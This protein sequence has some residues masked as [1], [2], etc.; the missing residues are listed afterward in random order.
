MPEKVEA[1]LKTA[2]RLLAVKKVP[3]GEGRLR[4]ST[5]QILIAL[6]LM[7]VTAPFVERMRDGRLIEVAL[8]T[9]VLGSAVLGLAGRRRTL[10]WAIILVVPTLAARWLN[11]LRPDVVPPELFQIGGL[12]F[13]LYV[14]EH[15]LLFILHAPKVTSEVLCAAVATYLM[16]ALLWAIAYALTN[17]AIPGSFSFS[18]G[19]MDTR[20]MKGFNSMYFSLGTLTTLSYGDILPVSGVARMLSVMESTVGVFFVAMLISRLVSL[21]S[22]ARADEVQS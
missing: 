15:Y 12:L 19:S 8:M 18:S 6:V 2:G 16:L 9:V 17:Q 10:I 20:E 3:W 11:H 22:T 4:F 7:F 5:A 13:L 14:V 21:Y 1:R